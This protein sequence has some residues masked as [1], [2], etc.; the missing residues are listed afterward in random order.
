MEVD[1]KLKNIID[2]AM[3]EYAVS[4]VSDISL[5]PRTKDEIIDSA[6]K[7]L[8]EYLKTPINAAN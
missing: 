5:K 7:K 3:T 8:V 4:V 2:S 1:I 6:V